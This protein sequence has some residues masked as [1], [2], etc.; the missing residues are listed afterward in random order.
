MWQR[1]DFD[2]RFNYAVQLCAKGFGLR[3]YK[4]REASADPGGPEVYFETEVVPN[5]LLKRRD[6]ERIS[7]SVKL[8]NG[9]TF[10]VDAHCVWFLPEEAEAFFNQDPGKW[11]CTPAPPIIAPK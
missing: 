9:G 2:D 11:W 5:E 1:S 7:E 3:Y 4:L 6:L 8:S 10:V